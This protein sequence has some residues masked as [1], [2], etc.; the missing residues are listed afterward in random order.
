MCGS[1]SVTTAPR[2]LPQVLAID[3][4]QGIWNPRPGHIPTPP[5]PRPVRARPAIPQWLA[6]I[7]LRDVLRSVLRRL[8]RPG[9]ARGGE[10]A[11]RA[12]QGGLHPDRRARL[13]ACDRRRGDGAVGLGTKPVEQ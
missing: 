1:R 3:N 12:L 8:P 10:I 13:P 5:R 6:A 9:H 11:P 7:F 2:S 4:E